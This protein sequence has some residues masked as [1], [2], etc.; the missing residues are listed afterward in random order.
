MQEYYLNFF[1]SLQSDYKLYRRNPAPKK[2]A[3]NYKKKTKNL[4]IHGKCGNHEEYAF[5]CENHIIDGVLDEVQGKPAH[6]QIVLAQDLQNASCH[7]NHRYNERNPANCI[8]VCYFND[9]IYHEIEP[10]YRH[11]VRKYFQWQ[12]RQLKPIRPHAE[13]V[14]QRQNARNCQDQPNKKAYPVFCVYHLITFEMGIIHLA[15]AK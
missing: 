4:Q 15:Y 13:A 5:Y 6:S 14:Q 1:Q 7:Y 10:A 3:R 9:R 12:P 8:A 11:D 2:L